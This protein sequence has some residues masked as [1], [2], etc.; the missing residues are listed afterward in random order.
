MDILDRRVDT[1]QRCDLMGPTGYEVV[2]SPMFERPLCVACFLRLYSGETDGMLD[3][4]RTV[5]VKKSA[6]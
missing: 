4:C 1:C 3:A 2:Q 5:E 6:S